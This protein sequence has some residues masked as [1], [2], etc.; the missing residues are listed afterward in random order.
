MNYH[1]FGDRYLEVP[2][3]PEAF[4][5]NYYLRDEAASN[6]RITVKDSG[7]QV[8]RQVDGPAKRGLNRAL[9]HLAGG[10]GR[11]GAGGAPVRASAAEER[12]RHRPSA[13]GDYVVTLDVAG[14]TLSKPAR[15][16]ARIE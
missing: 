16:R 14:V 1:L 3:E 8:V 6:A 2:N 5:V 15:V 4:A 11:G 13:A 10:G 9:V 7:G 12:H